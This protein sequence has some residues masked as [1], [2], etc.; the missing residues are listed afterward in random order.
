MN[1]VFLLMGL[2]LLSYLGNLLMTRRPGSR[3]GLPSGVEFAALGFVLGPQLLDLV[4]ARDLT[5]FEPVVQVAIGWLA[6][7]VGLDFGFAEH[8]RVRAGS[9]VLGSLS[10]LLTG[11]GVAAAI[12]FSLRALRTGLTVTDRVLLSGGLGAACSQTTRYAVSQ[13]TDRHRMGESPLSARLDEVAH[14]DG[15]L[16]LVAVAVLFAIDPPRMAFISMPLWQW[17]AITISLAI[18]LAAG[19]ALLLRDEMAIEDTWG[20]LF[21]VMLLTI[22]IAVCAGVSSLAASFFMG[23]S[24]SSFSRHR[25]ELRELVGPTERP[26]LLPALLLAGARLDFRATP[27]LPWI[28]A[29]ALGARLTAKVVVGWVLA[30]VLRSARRGGLMAGLSFMSCGPLSICIALAFALRFPGTVGDTVLVV[31]VLSAIVGEIVGPAQLR[32]VLLAAGELEDAAARVPTARR[33]AA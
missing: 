20:I 17:P 10:A 9:L 5:A 1:T 32:R 30:S 2:L 29:A 12:W 14:S 25:H 7:G 6:F 15:L 3:G 19:A 22:G 16:P 11:L 26:V 8:R 28:I 13:V 4:S 21:G 31:A 18:L 24:L 27:A 33:A 23:L